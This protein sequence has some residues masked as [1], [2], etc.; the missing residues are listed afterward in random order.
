MNNIFDVTEK[1]I[2]D[3]SIV[4]LQYHTHQ[5]NTT[6][7]N[8]NDEMRISVEGD[9]LTLPSLSHLYIEG[10]VLDKENHGSK[11]AK[12]VN[13]GL[14]HIFSEIRYEINGIPIDTCT[15]V[16]ITST[17]KGILS[18][19]PN[20]VKKLENATWKLPGDTALPRA[21]DG[22]F[23]ATLPLA[24]LLGFAEDY[25]KV[26]LNIRQELVL[27]RSNTDSDALFNATAA[28]NDKI[29]IDK[30]Y[31]RI[32]HVVPN[33]QK[34]LALTKYME[35]NVDTTV[36]FRS[37]ELHTLTG[38]PNTKIHS[39]NIK[40]VKKS[41]SPLYVILAFQANRA[42]KLEKDT[43]HFEHCDVNNIRVYLNSIK[44]PYDNLN[45]NFDG[46]KYSTLYDMYADF[47]RSYYG[48][49]PEPLLG[50]E[51]YKKESPVMVIDCSK[52]P[53]NIAY[54]SQ[55]INVRIE[56]ETNTNLPDNTIAYCL[57]LY[58]RKFAYNA[59]TKYVK[60]L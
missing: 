43:S 50:P 46:E 11:T 52:Q 14:A 2:V 45:I 58:E 19:T 29:V 3:N 55:A 59:L 41:Q 53:E 44:Y 48:V 49:E 24:T 27:I 25:K 5:S 10:R 7:F 16:G 28:A 40:S 56:F 39:W 37:W 34:E 15:K 51:I 60:Q 42:G 4:D 31:W 35:K 12:F 20:Q 6:S 8:Y 17:L 36:P 22:S 18:Y 23:N 38:L 30:L 47:Q 33:L 32:P 1:P 57:L 21:N 9:R 54:Q 26:I 13:N